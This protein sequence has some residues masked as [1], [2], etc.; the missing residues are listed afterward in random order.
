MP[1]LRSAPKIFTAIADAVAWVL[2]CEGIEN[3]LHYLDDFL[4]IGRPSSSQGQEYRA[5][6]LQSLAKL[7]IPVAAHKTQGPTSSLTFLG[8]LL[9][10]TTFELHFPDDKLT[11]LQEALQQWSRKCS[12]TKKE[13]ESFLGHLS[14]AATVIPQGRVFLRQLF[15]LLTL[16][17]QPQQYIRLNLGARADIKWW[18]AFL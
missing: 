16:D 4:F 7:G 8:I 12:C 18:Q 13:L 10:T 6:A 3:Q 2:T 17:R 9:D 14:H 5:V 11:R 1:Y 15:M